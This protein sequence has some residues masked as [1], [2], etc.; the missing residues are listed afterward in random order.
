MASYSF[1]QKRQASVSPKN[2]NSLKGNLTSQS[3]NISV[4]LDS[5]LMITPTASPTNIGEEK[6]LENEKC[7]QKEDENANRS[8]QPFVNQKYLN[9]FSYYLIYYLTKDELQNELFVIQNKDCRI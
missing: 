2:P 9:C 6:T 4:D 3:C 1:Q 7:A 5:S 8:V